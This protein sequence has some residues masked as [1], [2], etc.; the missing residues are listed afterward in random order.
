MSRIFLVNVGLPDERARNSGQG[1][2]KG[3]MGKIISVMNAKGGVG[4][5]TS[6]MM[7]AETLATAFEKRVLIIDADPQAS[8]SLM[9]LGEG[10]LKARQAQDRTVADLI[11]RLAEMGSQLD[12]AEFIQHGA[13]DVI[14]ASNIDILVGNVEL[15]WIERQQHFSRDSVDFGS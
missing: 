12:L 5:S 13:S 4:K 14:G 8:I 15:A 1:V 2:E 10:L 9:M 7:L 3:T 11:R 6:T